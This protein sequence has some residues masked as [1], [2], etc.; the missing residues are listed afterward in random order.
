MRQQLQIKQS[1]AG[2]RR[3]LSALISAMEAS[4]RPELRRQAIPAETLVQFRARL[5]LPAARRV[6][7]SRLRH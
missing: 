6:P 5:A 7:A 1:L 2:S 3:W 4:E